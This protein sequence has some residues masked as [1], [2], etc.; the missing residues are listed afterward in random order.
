MASLDLNFW[1]DY[2]FSYL[3]SISNRVEQWNGPDCEETFKKVS[4][5][6]KFIT[7]GKSDFFYKRNSRGFRSDNFD[8]DDDVKILYAGCS[9][10]EGVGLPLEHTWSHFVN[11]FIGRDLSR[12]LKMYNIGYG[13]FSIDA[14][15]RF[16]Y[17]TVKNNI[18]MPDIVL[19][20]LPSITRNEILFRNE[21][22]EMQTYHFISTFSNM[23]EPQLKVIHDNQIRSFL[24]TQRLHETFRNLLF[25]KEF[26][27]ARGIPFFFQT[28]DNS[29]LDFGKNK[30]LGFSDVLFTTGP[31]D[32]RQHH[33]PASMI[34]DFSGAEKH[35]PQPFKQNIGRDGMHPGPNSHWN[36]SN[37]FYQCLQKKDEFNKVFEKWKK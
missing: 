21:Y 30:F 33:I 6:P 12:K 31:K 7:Y 25:L 10:T 15:V 36:F 4:V 16:T 27:D 5:N 29:K 17:L 1:D 22:G 32:L 8:N 11:S 24:T 28:W 3:N 20:L 18:L 37:E 2:N 34:F 13:G 35:L 14:I 23:N 9:L 26:L 19:L